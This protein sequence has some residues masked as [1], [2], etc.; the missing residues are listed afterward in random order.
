M[1]ERIRMGGFNKK[2]LI[3]FSRDILKVRGL[4]PIN[5][6]KNGCVDVYSVNPLFADDLS[7][8]LD[9]DPPKEKDLLSICDKCIFDGNKN[10]LV[11]L[12]E[13]VHRDNVRIDVDRRYKND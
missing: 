10:M 7:L 9:A 13:V 4:I 11:E 5:C 1:T 2:G 8:M 6:P 3:T 12:T